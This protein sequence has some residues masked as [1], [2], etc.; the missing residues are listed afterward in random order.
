MSNTA[1][2][3]LLSANLNRSDTDG[4]LLV[5]RVPGVSVQNVRN[6]NPANLFLGSELT[7]TAAGGIITSFPTFSGMSCLANLSVTL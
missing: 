2:L 1:V 7:Q 6:A 4:T 5:L 3:S